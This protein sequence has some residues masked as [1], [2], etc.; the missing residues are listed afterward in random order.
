MHQGPGFPDRRHHPRPKGH[1]RHLRHRPRPHHHPREDGGRADAKRPSAHRRDGNPVHGQQG[2]A[3]GEDRRAGARQAAGGHQ[4]HPRRERPRGYAHRH[5]AQARRQFRCRAQL[6]VQAHADAG[7]LRRNHAGA[8]GWRAEGAL[9]AP[10]ALPL[11]RAPEGRHRAPHA[12]RSGQGRG[13]RP[14]S[15][16]LADR[17]GQHRRD[18]PYHPQQPEHGG[19]EDAAHG[20]LCPH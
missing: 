18:C 8:G 4:R 13:A 12:L 14:H 10:D 9:P 3:G 5:R 16:R 20:A 7:I 19:G 15:G 1:L 11:P 17:A 2:H 6:P